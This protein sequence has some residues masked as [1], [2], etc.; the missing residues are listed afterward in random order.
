M[1]RIWTKKIDLK[2]MEKTKHCT[3]TT[4]TV[5][6]YVKMANEDWKPKYVYESFFK[7]FSFLSATEN[8][9]NHLIIDFIL[10]RFLPKFRQ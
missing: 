3:T 10:F 5:E 1:V 6:Y 8:L 2:K 9:E 7:L 4:T